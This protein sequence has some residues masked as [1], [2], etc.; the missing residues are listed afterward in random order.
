MNKENHQFDATADFEKIEIEEKE[1]LSRRIQTYSVEALKDGLAI[2]KIFV[3]YTQFNEGLGALD[4]VFQ[5]SKEVSMSHGI[6]VL[7]PPGVGKTALLN[8][9]SESLPRSSLFAPGL[10]CVCIRASARPT[11][12]QILSSLLEAYKYPFISSSENKVYTR[13]IHALELVRIKGTRLV[14]IDEAHNLLRQVRR[15]GD[16]KAEPEATVFL[17][18]LMDSTNVALV[19]GGTDELDKL[20]D[21]DGHLADRITGRVALS[22]FEPNGEWLAFLLAFSKAC[23]W[24]DIKLIEDHKQA[25]RLHTATGGSPRHLKRL[26]TEA[27]LVASQAKCKLLHP[28]HFLQAY[29]LIYGKQS[30][31]TN[32]YV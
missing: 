10:G 13:K 9:F 16:S 4:R 29:I 17:C 18:E 7:G 23:T 15:R 19:L 22:C 31:R 25:K 24:F 1:T 26:L 21:V 14:F 6:R 32:P 27:V 30:L 11:T 5:I 12:G 8:Y 3:L 2:D 20:A 28:E